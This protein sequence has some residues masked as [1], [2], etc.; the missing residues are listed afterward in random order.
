M[1]I[2]F[3]TLYAELVTLVKATWPDILDGSDARI[4]EADH[5]AS[6]P[7]ENIQGDGPFCAIVFPAPQPVEM[8]VANRCFSL[9][10][11]FWWAAPTA[12]GSETH[13]ERGEAL[14]SALWQEGRVPALIA[15]GQVWPDPQPRPMWG[16]GLEVNRM[17]AQKKAGWL[18]GGALATVLVGETP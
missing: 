3:N 5:I 13:R 1:A 17:L 8:G 7:L 10:L 2:P 14:A 4:W 18:A 6:I 12:Q 9:P 11:E 16:V 15:S